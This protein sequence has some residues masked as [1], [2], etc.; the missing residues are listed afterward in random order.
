MYK[1]I[2]FIMVV[3]CG[4]QKA[5]AMSVDAFMDKHVA[6]ILDFIASIIFYP[7]KYNHGATH[8]EV[9]L[10][11]F[12]ILLAGVFFT[13]YFKGIAV[14]G[15][16]HAIDLISKPKKHADG[17]GDAGEVSSFQALA[18]ALSGTVGIGSIAGVAISISIGGPG[19]HSGYFSEHCSE[20]Q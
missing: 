18:T 2:A 13:F 10:I 12:W 17:S 20:C 3:C 5:N 9:P 19:P 11:I 8:I 16:K 7:I 15:F 4:M 1:L 14:W 6:P